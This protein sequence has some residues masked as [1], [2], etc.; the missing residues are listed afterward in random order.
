MDRRT[1]IDAATRLRAAELYDEGMMAVGRKYARYSYETKLAAARTVVDGGDDQG[2]GH[3]GLRHRL[4][5]PS[6]K[7]GEGVSGGR[8]RGAQAQAEGEARRVRLPS[9]GADARAGARASHPEA[10]GGERLPKK[11]DR[12]EGGEA[13]S[14]REKE[15]RGRRPDPAS[16]VDW[17]YQQAGWRGRLEGAGIVQ[18]MSRKGSRIDNGATERVFGHMKYEF[19][20]GRTWADFESFKADLDA[21]VVH[22]NTRRR[23]VKLKGLTPEEFRNQSLRAA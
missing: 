1:I 5:D 18:S 16:D 22:W 7:L 6:E 8:S 14:N 11:I 19:F 12:P 15:A 13:L 20:R 21:C 17:R 9:R 4:D 2:R 3:G 10:R 23:Q